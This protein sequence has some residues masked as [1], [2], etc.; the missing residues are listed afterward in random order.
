[1]LY[2]KRYKAHY[3]TQKKLTQKAN[4][5]LI[6]LI[7]LGSTLRDNNVNLLLKFIAKQSTM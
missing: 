3:L 1:M 7:L 4:L 2:I 5:V 6:L